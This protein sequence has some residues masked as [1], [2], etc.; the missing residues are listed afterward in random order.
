[1][2]GISDTKLIIEFT[3][4]NLPPTSFSATPFLSL[5]FHYFEVKTGFVTPYNYNESTRVQFDNNERF[6]VFL[7]L[8]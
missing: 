2:V 3:G 7:N 8:N 1:M 4:A 5:Y 6:D